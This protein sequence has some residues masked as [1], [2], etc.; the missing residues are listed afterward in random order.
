[1]DKARKIAETHHEAAAVRAALERGDMQCII[2]MHAARVITAANL[3]LVPAEKLR[4][5]QAA[6]DALRPLC[7]VP[8]PHQD[9]SSAG[10]SLS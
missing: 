9:L 5:K 3:I 8:C 7:M 10:P 4:T 1:M 6:L 2:K